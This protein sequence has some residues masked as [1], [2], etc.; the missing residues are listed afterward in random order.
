MKSQYK[1]DF[2]KKSEVSSKY[3]ESSL[4]FKMRALMDSEEMKFLFDGVDGVVDILTERYYYVAHN[5]LTFRGKKP[6]FLGK[7]F[8]AEKSDLILFIRH[9]TKCNDLRSMLLSPCFD[10]EPDQVIH[11]TEDACYSYVSSVKR[12]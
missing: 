2:L 7:V 1:F 8:V 11:V 4:F 9:S 6:I 3:S 12:L 10:N 5:L